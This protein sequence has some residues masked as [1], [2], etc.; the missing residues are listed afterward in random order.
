[1]YK[2]ELLGIDLLH[3]GKQQVRKEFD[4]IL[5]EE[6]RNSIAR[7][8]LLQPIVVQESKASDTPNSSDSS[9]T[10]TSF[11]IIAGER[12]YRACKELG[13]KKMMCCIL[14]NEVDAITELCL[15]ENLQR[16]DLNPIEEAR[17]YASMSEKGF[18]QNDI[19][20]RVG[21]SRSYIANI[22]RVLN[23]PDNIR[24]KLESGELSVGHA[25]LLLQSDNP[26]QLADMIVNNKLS[27]HEARKA[28]KSAHINND[29][30]NGTV[31]ENSDSILG[32][33][34]RAKSNNSNQDNFNRNDSN[35]ADFNKADLQALEDQIARLTHMRVSLDL[36]KDTITMQYNSLGDLDWL[37]EKLSM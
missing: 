16:A 10:S 6:L 15:I 29:Y 1:M 34:Q 11:S 35:K 12:R 27:V 31:K 2:T 32:V 19:A 33:T 18:T 28:V 17:A 20:Q 13:F 22:L 21:K 23:L 3:P 14:P 26:D 37:L 7:Y 4:P 24:V 36:K 8:G 30:K 25:H 9:N 5:L